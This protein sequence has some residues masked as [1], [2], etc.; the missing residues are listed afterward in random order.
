MFSPLWLTLKIYIYVQGG[1]FN[2]R[3]KITISRSL[4]CI[5]CFF[6]A[7]EFAIVKVRSS[8]I[9]QLLEEGNKKP[10]L[11]NMLLRI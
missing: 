11:P 3:R 7:T 2:D 6:V 5:N 9:N 8:K 10:S 4:N 1:D